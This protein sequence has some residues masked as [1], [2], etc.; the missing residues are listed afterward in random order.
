MLGTHYTVHTSVYL[1]RGV[2]DDQ[3]RFVL[4]L[5]VRVSDDLLLL[6]HS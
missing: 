1:F 6:L 4:H 3:R 2:S 5:D